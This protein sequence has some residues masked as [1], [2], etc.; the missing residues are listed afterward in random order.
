MTQR[1]RI[2]AIGVAGLLLAVGLNWGFGKYRSALQDRRNKIESLEAKKLQ[3]FE[4]Q[5]Q[6]EYAN[7]QMGEYLDRSLPG[8]FE[9]ARS[10]YQQ[11]LLDMA[12]E[13]RLQGAHV[14]PTTST[15]GKLF[16]RLS[17]RVSGKTDVPNF[18]NLLHTF[19]AKDYLHRIR[20]ME[21][22][23]NRNDELFAVEMSIDAI[24]LTAAADDSAEPSNDSWRVHADLATYHEPIMNRNFFEPPNQAPRYTGRSTLEA[25]VGRDSPLPLTFKDPEGHQVSYQ[26]V[27][28][29]PE[30]VSF[31]SGSG[32]LRV[33]SDELRE[34]SVTVSATDT[35]F[36]P[37][38]TEQELLVKVVE[39]PKPPAGP[40]PTPEFDDASQTVLTALVQSGNDWRAWMRVRT[41]DKTLKLRAGDEFEIGSVKGK[42]ISVTPKF[43]ELQLEE[44]RRFTLKPGPQDLR[45]AANS[46]ME[47]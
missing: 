37:R 19:Y 7:R 39:A 12:K 38:T 3:L 29:A 14:D 2:L 35:G 9:R 16:H 32:T 25:F 10:K 6:G 30:F 17:F 20:S 1:E 33:N 22:T 21:I 45:D 47:D 23:P 46:A 27:G 42:V 18:L 28:E 24:A 26:L 11:W 44:D 41:R 5:K 36:P 4:A 15:E 34:F 13:T 8:D 40:P 31:D 43:V